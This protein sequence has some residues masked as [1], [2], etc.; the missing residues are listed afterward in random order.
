[1][2]EKPAAFINSVD[3]GAEICN[4]WNRNCSEIIH[5][6]GD[7]CS[8]LDIFNIYGLFPEVAVGLILECFHQAE[9]IADI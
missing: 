9:W 6:L 4:G 8:G 5:G 3:S 1:M 7:S 2:T